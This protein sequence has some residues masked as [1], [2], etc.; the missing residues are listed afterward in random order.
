MKKFKEAFELEC[1]SCFARKHGTTSPSIVSKRKRQAA[2]KKTTEPPSKRRRQMPVGEPPKQTSTSVRAP[3]ARP[4]PTAI[5]LSSQE[6]T[7]QLS[8][9]PG[10]IVLSSRKE[11]RVV[12]TSTPLDELLPSPID[13]I[14]QLQPSIT[15]SHL[16]VITPSDH[17]QLVDWSSRYEIPIP[18]REDTVELRQRAVAP[19]LPAAPLVPYDSSDEEDVPEEPF[20]WHIVE[21]ALRRLVCCYI[22]STRKTFIIIF[23]RRKKTLFDGIGH[24]FGIKQVY[25]SNSTSWRCTCR[26]GKDWCRATVLQRGEEFIF[27]KNPHTCKRVLD[28]SLN[29]QI[30]AEVKKGVEL[31]K[32]ASTRQ[33]VEPI[34][35]RHFE[36]DPDRNLPVLENVY[37]V[38]QRAK[39]NAFPKNPRNLEFE[40][41]K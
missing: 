9:R 34:V 2:V 32:F 10:E 36:E 20:K 33:I 27:G 26:S 11:T 29:A 30:L 13:H 4:R 23:Y 40:W 21:S 1:C 35:M 38:A 24:S 8:T 15:I 19:M 14:D 28:K 31:Q 12:V 7:T 6:K 37:R 39:V 41:G 3:P 5:V 18:L 16:I 25:K 22:Q 17:Q